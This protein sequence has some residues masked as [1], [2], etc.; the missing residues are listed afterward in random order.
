MKNIQIIATG[1]YLPQNKVNNEQLAKELKTTEEFIYKRTGIKTRY[2]SENETV[3]QLAIKSVD[4]LIKKASSINI[5]NIDIYRLLKVFTTFLRNLF[6]HQ[7]TMFSTIG[8]NY[9]SCYF[10]LSISCLYI[11]FGLKSTLNKPVS[12]TLSTYPHRKVFIIDPL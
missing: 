4:D 3:E 2:Y 10:I 5:N 9:M 12:K 6:Q 8:I 1:S 11:Y 7:L